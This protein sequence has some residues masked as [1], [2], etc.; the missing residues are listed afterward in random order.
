MDVETEAW[1]LIVPPALGNAQGSSLGNAHSTTST[2]AGAT[3]TAAR[4]APSSGTGKVKLEALVRNS[5]KAPSDSEDSSRGRGPVS[6]GL[7]TTASIDSIGA[8]AGLATYVPTPLVY[9]ASMLTGYVN[10]AMEPFV[11]AWGVRQGTR[12][13]IY[14]LCICICIYVYMYTCITY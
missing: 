3:T 10:K 13:S 5:Y 14:L 1:S 7:F 2:G 4:G 6:N 12:V 8:S 11:A 9:V